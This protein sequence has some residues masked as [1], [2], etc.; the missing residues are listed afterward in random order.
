MKDAPKVD[1]LLVKQ[2]K[3]AL[4]SELQKKGLTKTDDET[5]DLIAIRREWA[6]RSTSLPTTQTGDMVRVVP[7]AAGAAV[8]VI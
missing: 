1:D 6:Q 7:G 4:D 5:A 3:E 2:I 8:A